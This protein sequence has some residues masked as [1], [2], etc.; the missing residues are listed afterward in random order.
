MPTWHMIS[1]QDSASPSMEQ[2]TMFHDLTMAILTLI[3]V[4][5]SLNLLFIS[6]YKLTD[7]FL[8]QDQTIEIIWTTCPVFILLLIALPSLQTLYLLDDPFSPSLTI[9]AIGHQWY[10]SYEYSDFPGIEFDAY[11]TPSLDLAG[12][13]RLLETD[14]SV[15]LPTLSQIRLITTG[16]DVIHAWTVPALGVK[17]DAVPGRLNQLLFSIKRPGIFYG[18]CS[19][20]CGSNHSFMPIKIEALPMNNFLSW[21][22]SLK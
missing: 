7:R 5:V 8:L 15:A 19:E 9:K 13:P 10:W 11:M 21:I 20:I 2:L 18:Q 3:T 1:F 6:F 14:N 16:A 17:A 22:I 4:L 12:L